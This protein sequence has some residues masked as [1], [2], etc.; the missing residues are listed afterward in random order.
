MIRK[1]C[2]PSVCLL[3]LL[4]L[5]AEALDLPRDPTPVLGMDALVLNVQVQARVEEGRLLFQEDLRWTLPIARGR[6]DLTGVAVPLLFPAVGDP[7]IVVD[8][9]VPPT[10][11][12]VEV[13]TSG[14]LQVKRSADSLRLQGLVNAGGLESLRVRF[15]LPL[16]ASTLRLGFSGHA[17]GQTWL[18][19]NV[20]AGPPVRVTLALD[21]PG[22]VTR[23]EEGRER[24]V[25]AS[26]A[27]PLGATEVATVTLGDLP[28]PARQPART[29]AWLAGA[30]AL[31]G[32]AGL[33]SRR[34][35]ANRG[36]LA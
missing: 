19:L 13:E 2:R 1:L 9:I 17:A 3:W 10:T 4:A 5:P 7:P 22:L 12:S 16:S 32:L 27:Q 33:V 25:S 11:E 24:L 20:L 23:F 8:H 28:T 6:V 21:R 18:A 29:L 31:T 35:A 34:R 14:A 15:A 26:L 36:P 30:V